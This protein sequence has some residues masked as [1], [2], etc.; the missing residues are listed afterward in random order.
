[1][2]CA[3]KEK[4]LKKDMR[5]NNY[6]RVEFLNLSMSS[7]RVFS[8]DCPTFLEMMSDIGIYKK[9]QHG[10]IKK[11]INLA[12]RATH[13]IFYSGNKI[14]DSPGYHSISSSQI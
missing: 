5:S 1:M 7:L 10:V 8:Y 9:Q 13:F 11:R 6:R 4:Y 12:I 3:K 2:Q 14:W